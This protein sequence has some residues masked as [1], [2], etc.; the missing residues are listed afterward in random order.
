MAKPV[1][2]TVSFPL[3][4]YPNGSRTSG[5]VSVADT[6]T[7]VEFS[8]QRCTSVDNTIWPNAST[9]L[10]V[11]VDQSNDGG[12]TWQN[13]F[14]FTGIGGIIVDKHGAEVPRSFVSTSLNPGTSRLLRASAT[15]AGGPLR[16]S[17]QFDVN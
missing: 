4:N 13:V 15:I 10:S 16:T 1:T 14:G 9:T 11:T 6:D 8:V 17:G 12:A 5:S 2:T 3:A 7:S